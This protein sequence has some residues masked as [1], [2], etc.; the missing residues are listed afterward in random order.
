MDFLTV[1]T[2]LA[3][4]LYLTV[5]GDSGFC[6]SIQKTVNKIEHHKKHKNSD[7]DIFKSGKMI[8]TSILISKHSFYCDQLNVEDKKKIFNF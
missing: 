1:L 8:L 5:I 6:Y 7:L 4:L 2:P 3:V